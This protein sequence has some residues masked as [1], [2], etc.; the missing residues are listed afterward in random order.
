MKFIIGTIV[1]QAM[2]LGQFTNEATNALIHPPNSATSHSALCAF[3]E[4]SMISIFIL[5]PNVSLNSLYCHL[6]LCRGSIRVLD[7]WCFIATASEPL[8][9]VIPFHHTLPSQVVHQV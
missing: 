9:W 5:H 2:Q 3:A 8:M 7:G 4:V 1:V 6:F